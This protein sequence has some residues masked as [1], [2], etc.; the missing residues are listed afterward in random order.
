MK[1]LLV[2]PIFGVTTFAPTLGLGFI[3]TC[4][5]AHSDFEVEIVEPISR[6]ISEKQVLKKAKE[7]DV[8]GLTCYTESRFRCLDFARKV[9]TP[10]VSW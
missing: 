4:V 8:V 3:G 10:T 2:N 5:R 6:S 9:K 7:S 1:L